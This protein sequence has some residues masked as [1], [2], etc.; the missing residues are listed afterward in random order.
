MDS[1]TF[2]A[3]TGA[4]DAIATLNGIV[5]IQDFGASDIYTFD[6][7]TDTITS[8]LDINALNPAFFA[9]GGTIVGGLGAVSGG[10]GPDRLVATLNFNQVFEID[11]AT[12]VITSSFFP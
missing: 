2:A 12:G 8:V 3:G 1:D 9:G 4:F 7:V 11:P 5:Y 10:G 6:T